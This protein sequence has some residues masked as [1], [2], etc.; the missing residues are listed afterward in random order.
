MGLRDYYELS[1]GGNRNVQNEK[2]SSCKISDNLCIK[3]R[4]KEFYGI[5]SENTGKVSLES[6]NF[7]PI[8]YWNDSWIF[9]FGNTKLGGNLVKGKSR[10]PILAF[11][12]LSDNLRRKNKLR[13]NFAISHRY[14]HIRTISSRVKVGVPSRYSCPCTLPISLRIRVPF[15]HCAFL[16]PPFP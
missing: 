8:I 13:K 11:L 10:C 5:R 3:K 7:T 4:I 6:N 15:W 2:N 16:S 12:K 1:H 9:R 14:L